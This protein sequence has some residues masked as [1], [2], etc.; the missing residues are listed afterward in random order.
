LA[1]IKQ[2]RRNRIPTEFSQASH[3]LAP[4][5]KTFGTQFLIQERTLNDF[6]DK[7]AGAKHPDKPHQRKNHN[8]VQQN[9]MPKYNRSILAEANA[10]LSHVS[11][12]RLIEA[13]KNNVVDRD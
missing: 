11:N 2:V 3:G 7:L 10:L 12:T 9:H 6:N 8:V 13:V 4:K 1:F 5:L